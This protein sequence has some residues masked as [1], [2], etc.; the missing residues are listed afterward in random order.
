MALAFMGTSAFQGSIKWWSLRHR[1][2]HRFTDD[3]VNDP[4]AAT[5]GLLYSHVGWFF[6]KRRYERMDRIDQ[7]DL[8]SDPVVQF[9]HK[10]YVPLAVLIALVLPTLV[11]GFWNDALGAFIY[12]GLVTLV[13]ST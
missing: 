2:H 7:Q 6:V 4:Y 3:P 11:G 13:I 8:A 9:Q 5:K 10:Y 12:A 1:L